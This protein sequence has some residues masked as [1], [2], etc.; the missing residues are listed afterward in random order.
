MRT[1]GCFFLVL[2]VIGGGRPAPAQRALSTPSQLS[3]EPS[4]AAPVS[5]TSTPS[6]D[7]ASKAA[8]LTHI[9]GGGTT[10]YNRSDSTAPVM[11]LPV[12]TPLR[13]LGCEQSWCR[14]RTDAGRTGYVPAS[15]LSN[16]W[17][18]ISKAEGRLYVY[19]GPHLIET[20]PIDIGYNTYA[21]KVRRGSPQERDHW[22]TPEGPFYVVDKKEQSEFYKAL[23]LNYPTIADAERGL[24]QDLISRSEYE[25]IVRAQKQ[26]Q[27]PPMNTEL[28]GWIEIHGEGTGGKRNWTQGC[29][30]VENQVI[31]ALWTVVEVGTP[32]LIE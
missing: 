10:L 18:R 13:R 19:R 6:P 25:T 22:R 16:V 7:D 31:D 29:V 20:Y 1:I 11:R 14:V 24:K 17:L 8:S 5:M 28:G 4:V 23:L 15:A 32:V 27:M 2:A 30:A 26:A 3:E 21:D 9:V 12:R